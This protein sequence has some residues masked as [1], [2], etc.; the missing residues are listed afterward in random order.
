MDTLNT[1]EYDRLA[2][3]RVV[4]RL[5]KE[6]G[7]SQEV[8]SGLA[9]LARSHLAM[10]ES[11]KKQANLETLWKIAAACEI[12][13]SQLVLAIERECARLERKN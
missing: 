9:G 5:R 3:G 11:G 10:I 4:R 13:P 1:A 2:M 7:L 6:R 12:R 8:F